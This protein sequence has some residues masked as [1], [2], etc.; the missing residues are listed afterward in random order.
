MQSKKTIQVELTFHGECTVKE[1]NGAFF[2]GVSDPELDGKL[3]FIVHRELPDEDGL[4]NPVPGEDTVEGGFQVNIYG[5]SEGYRE[6]GKYFLALAEL[7]TSADEGFHEH[8]DNLVS[9]D[10]RTRFHLI[11]RK[12]ESKI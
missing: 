11:L 2:G 1:R 3:S 9:S 12:G 6:L 8:L 5:D 4:W 7:N 10:G